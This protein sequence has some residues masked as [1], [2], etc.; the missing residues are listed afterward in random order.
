M[1]NALPRSFGSVNVVVSSE[2]ADGTRIPANTPWRARAVTSMVK[3]TEAPPMAETPAKPARP[4]RNVTLRP[5][6]S[7]SRPPSSSRLPKARVYAVTTHCRSTVL[8]CRARCADGSAMFITVRS[9]TTMSCAMAMTPRMSQRRSG[10]RLTV[11]TSVM[12]LTNLEVQSPFKLTVTSNGEDVSTFFGRVDLAQ[13]PGDHAER[14]PEPRAAP[15]RPLR[16]DAAR[17]RQ[18]VLKAASE[19]FTQ[20]GLD[21]SLDEVA[22]HAGVGVGTVYRRFPT[23]EHLVEALFVD[24]IEA[25]AALAED[26]AEAPDPGS[27]LASFMEQAAEWWAGGRARG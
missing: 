26:A 15:V 5:S 3:L 7:C 21:V 23:K 17:N 18:R 4:A 19:V 1:P 22:R 27:G 24:R 25:V 16:R 8:K 9:R 12:S 14:D 2:S 20:R 13:R 11:L 10:A 6:R